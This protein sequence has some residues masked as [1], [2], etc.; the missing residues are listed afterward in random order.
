LRKLLLSR[1]VKDAWRFDLPSVLYVLEWLGY[2]DDD[3]IFA[4]HMSTS[5]AS[6]LIHAVQF[7]QDSPVAKVVVNAGLLASQSPLPSYFFL[8]MERLTHF[9][10]MLDFLGF[11]DHLSI[12][13]WF[14]S[15]LVEYDPRLVPDWELYKRR[16]LQLLSLRSPAT[17]I[18]LF[19]TVFPELNVAAEKVTIS[20][21]VATGGVRLGHAVLGGDAALGRRVLLPVR[22]T[23]LVLSSD[24]ERTA[25]GNPWPAEAVERLERIIYPVLASVGA[26]IEVILEVRSVQSWARLEKQSYLGYDSMR[27]PKEQ[28]RRIRIFSGA[29]VR[30]GASSAA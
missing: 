20:R 15:V 2:R 30:P 21:E 25:T 1:L 12:S 3:V 17:L 7:S 23:R 10:E 29:V 16:E 24:E 9:R 5:S 28:Y 18:W 11:W 27:G 26:D 19:Q 8:E 22:G 14:R 4:S 6:S 13:H